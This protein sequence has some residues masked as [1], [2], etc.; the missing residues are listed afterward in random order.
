VLETSTTTLKDDDIM[1]NIFNSGRY[2]DKVEMKILEWIIS[3]E[4]KHTK[5][6]RIYAKVF[7]LDVPLTQSQPIESTKERHR[8]PSTPRLPNPK[9]DTVES[10][11]PK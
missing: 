9:M 1:K 2:K 10:S 11:A 8:T 3:E 4:M 7:G 6:Y 5:H